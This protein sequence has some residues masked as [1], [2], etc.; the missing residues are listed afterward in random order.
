[1][2]LII[3]NSSSAEVMSPSSIDTPGTFRQLTMKARPGGRVHA[4]CSPERMARIP[5]IAEAQEHPDAVSLYPLS[6]CSQVFTVLTLPGRPLVLIIC[7][8]EK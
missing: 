3:A 1:M 4:S 2:I 6:H 7:G 5:R 8:L